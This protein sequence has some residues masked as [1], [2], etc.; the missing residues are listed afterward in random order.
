MLLLFSLALLLQV[1]PVV[2]S[3]APPTVADTTGGIF[4]SPATRELVERVILESGEIPEGLQDYRAELRSMMYL[5]L[6]PDSALGGELPVTTDEFVGEVRWER[7]GFLHQWVRGH[8]MRLLAPAPYTLGTMIEEPWVIP[9][10]YGSTINLLS[11]GDGRAQ[12]GA[13]RAIHPFG[14][15]GPAH[16]R[17][18]AGDTLR[19]R[20]QNELVTLVP[21][22]V[23]PRAAPT[24][25]EMQ[26]VVG[27][28]FIDTDRA[29]VARA[30]FGFVEPRRG[31]RVG[32]T[33]VYLELENALW[34]NRYWLPFRQRQEIQVASG[35]F[36][37]AVAARMVN[38][39]G[40]YD[41]NTGWSPEIRTR[42]RLFLA[43]TAG[44]DFTEWDGA[45]GAEAAEWEIADFADLRRLA[46]GAGRPDAGPLRVTPRYERGDHLFRYNRVEGTYLGAGVRIEP[47]DPVE[48]R[49]ELYATAGWAFVES[50]ARGE[51][52]GRWHADA[53]RVPPRGIERGVTA[54]VYRRLRE[55]RAFQPTFRWDFLYSLPAL[56][57]GS[58][59]RDYY[60]ATGAELSLRAGTGSW[61]GRVGGRWE[62]QDSVRRNTG[63]FLF[64][65]AQDFP[66]LAP[67]DPG[68]HA[69]L[70]GA[71]GYS[72]GPGAFGIG[73]S[74]VASLRAEVGM[75]DFRTQRLIGLLSFRQAL[76]PIT[77][78]SRLDAGHG[79]GELPPQQLFRFGVEEGL[80]GYE[81]NEFGGS[82]AAI[83]RGR[84]LIGLP[85]RSTQPL[86]RSGFFIV[87]PLRP[88]LVLLGEAG[89]A[90][91]SERSRPQLA[92]LASV[93]TERVRGSLGVGVSIF[94]DALTLEW[95][96]PLEEDR[97]GRWYFGLV[98]WF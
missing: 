7:T 23:R 56:V 98:R 29:A 92:R 78:A 27:S 17:Y 43:P 44:A 10:L 16:Y 65:T 95:Y 22:E 87:P 14:S 55:V 36:G 85:P 74:A 42:S 62:R 3:P 94:E 72:R 12:R 97:R 73:N 40:S 80:L 15:Q 47:N 58:D 64:G 34:E 52:I 19:I 60:D 82:T 83:G 18:T 67:M 21:I 48:R 81:P 33:G 2:P 32:Q 8:R 84:L 1:P 39:F 57:G 45:V 54:G 11:A 66:P 50:T 61:I 38:L 59:L 63:S 13:R 6:A 46:A 71:V 49:W 31:L 28:F 70:E 68:T 76:G 25:R 5:T 35:L 86:A 26:L 4:D 90:E 37:G 41:L 75:A 53:P 51:L 69:A 96:R 24:E 91:V 77:F 88:S 93:P 79:W 20:L 9:H 89:W 30:R